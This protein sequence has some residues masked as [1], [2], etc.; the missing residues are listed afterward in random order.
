MDLTVLWEEWDAGRLLGNYGDDET[1]NQSVFCWE[2][3]IY[4]WTKMLLILR[5]R[6]MA[7]MTRVCCVIGTHLSLYYYN[8]SYLLAILIH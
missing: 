1:Y 4:F 2:S 7:S 5:Y 3:F 8:T 6:L